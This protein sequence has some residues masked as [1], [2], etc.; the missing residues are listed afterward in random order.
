[1]HEPPLICG[2]ILCR[3]GVLEFERS[4]EAYV[5]ILKELSGAEEE[6]DSSS[7]HGDEL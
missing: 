7:D 3:Y 5:K 2:Q 1:M 4:Q 6:A